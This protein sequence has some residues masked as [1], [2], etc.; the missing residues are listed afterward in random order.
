MCVCVSEHA[1]VCAYARVSVHAIVCAC[2]FMCMQECA[3]VYMTARV[4]IKT[5]VDVCM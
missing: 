5:S 4:Y 1:I 3:Y 2:D